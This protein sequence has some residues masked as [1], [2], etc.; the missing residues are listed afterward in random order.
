MNMMDTTC[1][2]R[3]SLFTSVYWG[4]DLALQKTWQ[5]PLACPK[6]SSPEQLV[7][8][9][10]HLEHGFRRPHHSIHSLVKATGLSSTLDLSNVSTR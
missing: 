8:S 2:I 9:L 4:L 6:M 1:N 3:G 5:I 10:K 7:F